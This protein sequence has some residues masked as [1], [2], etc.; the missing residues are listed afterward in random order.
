MTSPR[1]NQISNQTLSKVMVRD[2][3]C[4]TSL[5]VPIDLTHNHAPS[6]QAHLAESSNDTRQTSRVE[7]SGRPRRFRRR[8]PSRSGQCRFHLSCIIFLPQSKSNTYLILAGLRFK[9]ISNPFS[10]FDP[11]TIL[12]LRHLH[13]DQVSPTKRSTFIPS[14]L[15]IIRERCFISLTEVGGRTNPV[16][17]ISAILV[18]FG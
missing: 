17:R 15:G 3:L 8:S 12:S 13:A 9:A 16:S 18:L 4:R 2:I 6:P 1:L 14:D 10:T 11:N 5:T 7:E